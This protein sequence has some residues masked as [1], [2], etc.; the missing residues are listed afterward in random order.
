MSRTTTRTKR[1]RRRMSRQRRWEYKREASVSSFSYLSFILHGAFCIL[2]YLTYLPVNSTMA[3]ILCSH[4]VQRNRRHCDIVIRE[5]PSVH[6]RRVVSSS[7][8]YSLQ[9]HNF[10]ELSKS[11][12]IH[13]KDACRNMQKYGAFGIKRKGTRKKRRGPQE[14][15]L[16]VACMHVSVLQNGLISTRRNAS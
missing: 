5:Q 15:R 13:E 3:F 8:R 12:Q 6:S 16:E 10:A 7:W 11:R 9:L 1:R 2:I 4:L 14:S